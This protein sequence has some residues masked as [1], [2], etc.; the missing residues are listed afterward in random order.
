MH[1]I[2]LKTAPRPPAPKARDVDGPAGVGSEERR[3]AG[4]ILCLE[5]RGN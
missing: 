5:S 4:A 2:K 3:A 1:L